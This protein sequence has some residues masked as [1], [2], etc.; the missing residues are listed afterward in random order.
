MQAKLTKAAGVVGEAWDVNTG[1]PVSWARKEASWY[2]HAVE[3]AGKEW[4]EASANAR[5]SRADDLTAI[6]MCML[7]RSALARRSRPSD[8]D[9]REALSRW[10]FRPG[11]IESE[12]VPDRI[13]TALDWLSANTRPFYSLGDEQTLR[14]LLADLSKLQNGKQASQSVIRHRR[15]QLSRALDLGVTKKYLTLNPLPAYKPKRSDGRDEEVSPVCIPSRDQAARLLDALWSLSGRGTTKDRGPHLRGFFACM[16]YG[17]LRPAEV[18]ALLVDDLYLP[19]TGW[20]RLTLRGSSPEVGALWT[21]DGKAHEDR[22]LKHRSRKAVRVVP[23]PPALVA[24]LREHL[25]R[26]DPA[27]DGRIF[28]D[29]PDHK[30]IGKSVYSYLW[31]RARKAAFSEK[32][33]ASLVARRPYDLRHANASTLLSA[34]VNPAEVARRLGHTIKVLFAV[35]AHWIDTDT[36]IANA[37]IEA[38]FNGVPYVPHSA[39]TS[40]NV[41]EISG[42]PTGQLPES[43]AA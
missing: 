31:E 42:P 1:Q 28:W 37:K 40:A 41:P 33:V 14:A 6:T 2:D 8:K 43:A 39:V 30:K 21:D 25:N 27:P 10:A 19:A 7:D 35:Y 12:A 17:G 29:G 20:G 23:I 5:R 32:E 26:F 15:G 3:V 13:T 11:R 18:T 24:I 36:D 4:A 16:Y 38:A 9:L 22:S 34:N